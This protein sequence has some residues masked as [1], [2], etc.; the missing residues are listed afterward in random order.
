MSEPTK[1]EL[2]DL[3]KNLKFLKPLLDYPDILIALAS[4]TKKSVEIHKGRNVSFFEV[5]EYLESAKHLASS[6]IYSK[7][8]E[9]HTFWHSIER[10]L[11]GSNLP[12]EEIEKF[13]LSKDIEF[14]EIIKRNYYVNYISPNTGCVNIG[15]INYETFLNLSKGYIISINNTTITLEDVN[16]MYKIDCDGKEVKVDTPLKKSEEENKT[17]LIIEEDNTLKSSPMKEVKNNLN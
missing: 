3:P 4:N 8:K 14:P 12:T 6:F 5:I 13:Y 11:Q 1:L 10:F 17:K 9:G 2:L 7:S 15:K 16:Y